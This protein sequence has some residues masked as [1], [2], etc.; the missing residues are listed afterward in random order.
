MIPERQTMKQILTAVALLF[1][2]SACQHTDENR[3]EQNTQ[4]T[5]EVKLL[6]WP[7]A[8]AAPQQQQPTEK[9]GKLAQMGITTESG[10]IIIDTN[11]TKD[12]FKLM[13]QKIQQETQK[14]SQ[15]MQQGTINEKSAGIEV[16]Q[17]HINI[18]LNK[19]QHFLDTW[20]KKLEEYVK[21]F[22]TI[23]EKFEVNEQKDH[24][25]TH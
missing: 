2:L 9:K 4:T 18:D 12:F 17:T 10:K 3:A 1:I 16:N 14:L 6:T 7:K 5:Q 23:T 19:T 15:E 20:S 24:N 8:K 21:E 13:A 11:K 22:D 25:A